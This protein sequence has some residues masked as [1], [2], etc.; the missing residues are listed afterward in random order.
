[1]SARWL[2]L[3]CFALCAC[4]NH[5]WPASMEQEAYV[6]PLSEARLAPVGSV[7]VGGVETLADRED[8]TELKPPAP[9]DASAEARGQALFAIH[10]AVC[11]GAKARGDGL[12]SK[13]FPPAPDLRYA[14]ICQRADGF[15][16]GTITAGGRAMPS[17]REGTTTNDRWALVAFVRSLQREGCTGAPASGGTP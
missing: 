11:H 13:K 14:S 16:Y 2:A 3:G 17:M 4:S 8:D 7:P 9:F 5:L 6:R 12:V 10:C 15:I 1:V